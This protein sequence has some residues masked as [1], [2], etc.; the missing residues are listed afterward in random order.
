MLQTRTANLF[1]NYLYFLS[2]KISPDFHNEYAH[3]CFKDIQ[4]G[5]PHK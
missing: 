1:N 2:Q 5:S 3:L 4:Y